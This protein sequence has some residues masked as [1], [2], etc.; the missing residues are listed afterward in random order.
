MRVMHFPF[1]SSVSSIP[2]GSSEYPH[3]LRALAEPPVELRVIGRLP[4][5]TRSVALVGTRR[6]DEEALDFTYE[7]ARAFA[8]AG[9]VIVSGGALGIDR[10]AHEGALDAGGQTVLVLATG[11][12][13][14]YPEQNAD[15]FARAVRQAC[16]I[17][18]QPDGTAPHPGRFLQRNRIV[19]GLA[20]ATVVTQAPSRSGALSTARHAGAL[21][22]QV[23]A[24]PASPWDARS[25]GNLTL[26]LQG[27]RV[28]VNANDV[29]S[30]VTPRSAAS[31]PDRLGRSKKASEFDSLTVQ[32]AQI[33]RSLGGRARHP[34]ELCRQSGIPASEAQR[35]ILS[36]LV[37][38]LIEERPG[39]RYRS[40]RRN[41]RH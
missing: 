2:L 8:S 27:A 36:L 6:A 10:A 29:L 14:P 15:L 3:R 11:F 19:A 12:D 33:L 41:R 32:E 26:L 21:G 7:L 16:L 5:F 34:D 35:I 4:S 20:E 40:C 38:G 39:G 25:A 1:S 13:P 18:E 37:R 22:R 24:T 23:F 17:T 31:A 28:C 30:E 9:W